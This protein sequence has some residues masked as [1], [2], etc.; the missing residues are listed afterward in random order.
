MT[1]YRLTES[2]LRGLIREAIKSVLMEANYDSDTARQMHNY[3]PEFGIVTSTTVNGT[4]TEPYRGWTNDGPS[5]SARYWDS[6]DDY[7]QN[8]SDLEKEKQNDRSWR[9]YKLQQ[10]DLQDKGGVN[11]FKYAPDENQNVIDNRGRFA[12]RALNPEDKLS[13]KIRGTYRDAKEAGYPG[14]NWI[15]DL[16]AEG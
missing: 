4:T 11:H 10:Y 13:K 1:R 3:D 9:E 8:I 14:L 12:M 6:L 16:Q 2:R 7:T 5:D 15:D